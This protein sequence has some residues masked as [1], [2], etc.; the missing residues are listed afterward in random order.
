MR[1]KGNSTSGKRILFKKIKLD[2]GHDIFIK[3]FLNLY[4]G[5]L[6]LQVQSILTSVIK[7]EKIKI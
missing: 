5:M 7:K 4:I 3:I 2:L 1:P 6:L